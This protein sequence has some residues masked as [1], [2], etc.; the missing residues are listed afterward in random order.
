MILD[1]YKT[2]DWEK[3]SDDVL[4]VV[5]DIPKT[6]ENQ[7][8]LNVFCDR[9]KAKWQAGAKHHTIC[10]AYCRDHRIYISHEV[11]VAEPDTDIALSHIDMSFDPAYTKTQ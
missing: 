9:V 7:N 5:N 1:A 2:L 3:A 6:N 8:L 10:C 11:K 4:L